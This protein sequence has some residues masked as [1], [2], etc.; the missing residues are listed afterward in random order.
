[1]STWHIDDDLLEGYARSA[2]PPAAAWSVEAHLPQC[3][4]CRERI[5]PFADAARLDTVRGELIAA[6]DSPRWSR[7]ERLL[8]WLGV[9]EHTVRLLL[10]TPALRASWLLAVAIALALAVTATYTDR[11]AM[12]TLV[13]LTLAPI[14][15]LAGVATAYGARVD[16]MYEITVAAPISGFRLL[17]LRAVAVLTTTIAMVGAAALALPGT[18][19]RMAAWLLPALALATGSLALTPLLGSI[20]ATTGVGVGWIAVVLVTAVPGSGQALP[21][22][23]AG[24][25]AS[26]V[27]AVV[28]AT[29]LFLQRRIVDRG[30][31]HTLR[32][33]R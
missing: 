3:A 26:V 12:T 11:T 1:M 31:L 27:L 7:A 19:S 15:P 8:M 28:A 13:F 22:S 9:P 14:A 4:R 10:A 17:L 18:D 23:A 5:T 29:V 6:T 21:F 32:S 25:L 33:I 30:P 2:L 24:Q 16:P 20:A